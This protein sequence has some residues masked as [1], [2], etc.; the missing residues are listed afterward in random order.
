MGLRDYGPCPSCGKRIRKTARGRHRYKF[1]SLPCRGVSQRGK[2][3]PNF[4]TGAFVQHGYRLVFVPG[5]KNGSRGYVREHIIIAE[6][7]LGRRLRRNECVHHVNGNKLDNRPTNLEVM[8]KGAHTSLHQA[9]RTC[10]PSTVEKMRAKAIRENLT[11][12]RNRRGQY[13]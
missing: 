6:W 5:K 11:R 13:V 10:K 7:M 9:G 3:S 2:R 12:Q 1:C 4:R 8:T